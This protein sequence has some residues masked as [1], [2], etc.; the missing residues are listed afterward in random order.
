M[1]A[2]L[3]FFLYLSIFGCR[4]SWA[5]EC[6]LHWF[7]KHYSDLNAYMAD[8]SHYWHRTIFSKF[9]RSLVPRRRRNQ[10]SSVC[11]QEVTDC[12]SSTSVTNF[13]PTRTSYL[14]QRDGNCWVRTQN[15]IEIVVLN[16][17]AVT[18][19]PVTRPVTKFEPGIIVEN[20]EAL[21]QQLRNFAT[22]FLL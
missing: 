13:F 15:T 5:P 1:W 21:E 19:K 16:L 2:R 6:N 17:P 10:P 7:Q 4:K 20:K 9:A 14:T 11:N 12:S 22:N 18:L 8:G 3:I